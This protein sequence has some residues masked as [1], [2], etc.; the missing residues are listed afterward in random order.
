M[1]AMCDPRIV[2]RGTAADVT[3]E[4]MARRRDD[5]TD[6]PTPVPPRRPA[7]G[8]PPKPKPKPK[9]QDPPPSGEAT[10]RVT[11]L[12]PSESALVTFKPREGTV[13][14]TAAAM[15]VGLGKPTGKPKRPDD[16]GPG[17]HLFQNVDV[18][19]ALFPP[20]AKSA[21]KSKT[22][23]FRDVF[24]ETLSAPL[25]LGVSAEQ[26]GREWRCEFKNTGRTTA[27]VSGAVRVT[28]PPPRP[29]HVPP[30]EVS[31]DSKASLPATFLRAS[32]SATLLFE[33]AAGAIAVSITAVESE[34]GPVKGKVDP[35]PTGG[36]D[37][38][39]TSQPQDVTVGVE[40][41][42]GGR[43]VA[44]ATFRSRDALNEPSAV[45][46]H[47]TVSAAQAQR[48]WECVVR[49]RSKEAIRCAATVSFV[50]EGVRTE[51]PLALLNHGLRQLIAAI[52]LT[53]RVHRNRAEIGITPELASF[54]KATVGGSF[55]LPVDLPPPATVTDL[56]L[57]LLGIRAR[58]VD[59]RPVVTAH[60]RFEA[61]GE[62][63]HNF[64]FAGLVPVDA[65]LS[66]LAIR[67]DFTL[68]AAG[69]VGRRRIIVLP[70][71][72]VDAEAFG[73]AWSFFGIPFDI[74]S[75]VRDPIVDRIG[76]TL[77]SEAF[78]NA[79]RDFLTA[80]LVDLV[81]QGHEFVD[82]SATQDAWVVVHRD[83]TPGKRSGPAQ[84]PHIS[85]PRPSGVKP[86]PA[87]AAAASLERISHLVVL[88]LENRSFDH[89]LGYLSHPGHG[90]ERLE[91]AGRD[92]PDGLTGEESN[93]LR[94]NSPR[95][96]IAEYPADH[97]KLL[98]RTV[99]A[100]A[101]PFDPSHSHEPVLAQIAAGKM[102]GFAADF[103]K[104]F[105]NV[106]PQL[107]MS[108]YTELQLPVYDALAAQYAVCDR[109]FCS[110]PGP[111]QPN[112]FCALSGHTPVL[113]NF[114]VG[115]P[116]VA[117]LAMP[118]IFDV[119]SEAGVDWVYYEGD[120]GFLRMFDRYR[121]D[122]RN[123]VAYGDP[124]DGFLRRAELGLLPPVTFIDPNFA[125]IPPA[126][127]A[128]DDH[129][130]ADL[131]FGQRLV[132]EIHDALLRS[133]TW[134]DGDSGTLFVVTYDEH[135]GFFDHVAPPGTPESESAAPV[136]PIHPDG[137]PFYGPRVP[138]FAIG[139]FVRAGSVDSTIYDHTSLIATILRRFVNAFPPELGPRPALANHLGHVLT[140]AAP[141]PAKPAARIAVPQ[142][143]HGF[144]KV[145]READDF[146]AGMRALAQP[147]R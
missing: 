112:R 71:L 1:R 22:F 101:V 63:I 79:V 135:G 48:T 94:P 44:T 98:N 67:V 74:S 129:A 117:Y 11:E 133:P 77:Q 137:E 96:R 147:R 120:V 75:R 83:P 42:A 23:K 111:T 62:E 139:P 47:Q 130:P 91:R 140:L 20:G 2:W 118:T 56:N 33:P 138:T 40:L 6:K 143:L 115:D 105:P 119:L 124:Q 114:A 102:S 54:A 146:Q 35:N 26:A 65:D 122:A 29:D 45:V 144:R 132:A 99:P 28:P 106:D 15:Q 104:R 107:A 110:H 46:M 87:D 60:A 18:R 142:K 89:V 39:G 16:P 131:R 38:D 58:T 82:L 4:P 86:A 52:G 53:V 97:V 27:K 76:A 13:A 49:N 90:L 128:N 21:A 8:T 141:R 85:F 68:Q 136:A 55:T 34:L 127:T 88:M 145:R 134:V 36:G 24:D 93:P 51:L 125:D 31:I 37:G 17:P 64:L 12:G 43:A 108:F 57:H 70:T 19:V 59:G 95:V 50:S 80:G 5:D 32:D 61:T 10:L 92:V 78:K 69:D 103:A 126:A 116:I 113:D 123:V 14:V 72:A 25:E 84:P 100:T 30:A 66:R 9:P 121:L 109:W 41:R 73:E 81:Q 7:G 3:E